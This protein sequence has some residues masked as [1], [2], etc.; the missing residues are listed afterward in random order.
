MLSGTRWEVDRLNQAA[1]EERRQAGWLGRDYFLLDHKGICVGDRVLFTRNSLLYGV[2]N[3]TLGTVTRID[4]GL[5]GTCFRARL[6]NG[7]RVRIDLK[8][9]HDVELGY[10][11]T[12]HKAQ[13][14]TV[15]NAYVLLGGAMQDRELSYVQ[16]SRARKKTWLFTDQAEAGEDLAELARQMS[17]SHQKDLAYDVAERAEPDP[18]PRP[19]DFLPGGWSLRAVEQ[20]MEPELALTR[21]QERAEPEPEPPLHQEP[22]RVSPPP[23]PA[24]PQPELV[25]PQ[26]EPEPTLGHD[27]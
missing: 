14:V 13:G 2:K 4:S 9:Y 21:A 10:A 24:R 26:P 15:D 20:Q 27:L 19:W 3:G 17:Q 11:V 16:A 1:Q 5:F 25:P 7:K 12:T 8:F 23:E 22:E 18:A 6:D